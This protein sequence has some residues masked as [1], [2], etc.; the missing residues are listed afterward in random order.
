MHKETHRPGG[1][2]NNLVVGFLKLHR[3]TERWGESAAVARKGGETSV[4]R[5]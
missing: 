4:N 3:G 1:A 2:K 5:R